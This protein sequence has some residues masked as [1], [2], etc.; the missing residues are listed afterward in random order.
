MSEW[1]ERANK[2]RD[3]R[4]VLVPCIRPP[5]SSNKDTK[6]WCRGKVGRAHKPVCVSYN[7]LK[8]VSYFGQWKVLMCETC[9]KQLDHYWPSPFREG[10]VIPIPEWVTA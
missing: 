1:R 2:R 3:E 6:K 8:R 9:G 10:R 5:S 7:E 4:Q